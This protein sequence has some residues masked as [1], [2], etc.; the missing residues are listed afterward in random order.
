MC[1]RS[2]TIALLYTWAKLVSVLK[3][4]I[5]IL[6]REIV[7]GSLISTF[8][9]LLRSSPQIL[10]LVPLALNPKVIEGEE[11]KHKLT[12]TK[13]CIIATTNQGPSGI[14]LP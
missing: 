5:V 14:L 12:G 7:A 9:S 11:Q 10:L 1:L 2:R 4:A 6:K 3:L 8:V 13:V